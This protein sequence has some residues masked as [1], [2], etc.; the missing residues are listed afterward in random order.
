MRHELVPG[1]SGAD[2]NDA[3]SQGFTLDL[4]GQTIVNL[5]FLKI[6]DCTLY[7]C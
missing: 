7:S 3:G 1:V 4:C 6:K 2:A 5:V